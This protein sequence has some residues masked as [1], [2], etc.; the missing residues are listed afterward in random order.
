[1]A[2]VASNQERGDAYLSHTVYVSWGREERKAVKIEINAFLLYSTGCP[3][4]IYPSQLTF[5]TEL[6]S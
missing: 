4:Y 1:M 2:W 6:T 5:I 3:G